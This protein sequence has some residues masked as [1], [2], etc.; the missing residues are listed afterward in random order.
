MPRIASLLPSS[1][2]IC[3]LLG[4]ERD[5]VGVSHECDYPEGMRGRPILTSPK[6]NPH[7]SSAEIDRQ[8]RDLVAS[9]LSVYDIDETELRRLKPELIVTQDACEV[10]AVSFTEVQDAA[11]RL[12][13]AEVEV[14]SLSPLTL[15]DVLGD[16]LRVGRAT[17]TLARAEKA[18]H[19]LR[20]RLATL[21]Q[22]T[23]SLSRPRVVALEWLDPPMVA[24]HWTPELIEIAGGEPILGHH[25]KPTGPVAWEEIVA[26]EP[27]VILAIPCGFPVEQSMRE[28]PSLL[29]R[30]GLRKHS[31]RVAVADGNAFFNRPGPRL[32]E[33]AEIA[34]CAIHPDHFR[35]Q[36]SFDTGTLTF[37]EDA[38]DPSQPTHP[39][40]A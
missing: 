7:A 2:E 17:G 25:G 3:S 20:A 36:F 28:I 9:G 12:L 40:P 5:I 32:V 10:C 6:V 13:G 26:A 11:C 22:E 30:P 35:E 8:V 1:T 33:S 31:P 18:V 15:D 34:A 16:I 24:G 14:L 21:R 19:A 23:A 39:P 27:E 37:V 4:L 29:E 38:H